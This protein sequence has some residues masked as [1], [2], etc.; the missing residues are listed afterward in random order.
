LRLALA[1]ALLSSI[2]LS[3]FEVGL[4]DNRK[5]HDESDGVKHLK[6]MFDRHDFLAPKQGDKNIARPRKI[7][8]RKWRSVAQ[9]AYSNCKYLARAGE[10]G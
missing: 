1:S 2:H 6:E 9:K 3:E 7:G 4:D 8:P 10:V 5:A